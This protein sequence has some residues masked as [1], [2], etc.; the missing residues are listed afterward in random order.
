MKAGA[1]AQKIVAEKRPSLNAYSTLAFYTLFA[2]NYKAAEAAK[3]KAITYTNT[4]FERES[5]ENKF[6][7]IEKSAKEFAKQAKL[8]KASKSES[9]GK[10]SLENPLNGL[11]GSPLT[12]E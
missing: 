8:E 3:E 1:E 6:E 12:G 5:F 4:K 2:Q 11:G 7:E 9:A 10:E